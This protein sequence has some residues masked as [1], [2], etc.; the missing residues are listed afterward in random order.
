MFL[1]YNLELSV[2]IYYSS[3]INFSQKHEG[4]KAIITSCDHKLPYIEHLAG[5]YVDVKTSAKFFTKMSISN[6]CCLLFSSKNH[7]QK[8]SWF[9]QRN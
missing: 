2:I 3:N 6:K 1:H 9:L 7:E 8:M 4:F 5:V